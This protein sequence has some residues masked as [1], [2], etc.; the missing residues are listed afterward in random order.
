MR[1]L[2]AFKV[3]RVLRVLRVL[4]VQRVLRV[5]RVLTFL[6]VLRVLRGLRVLRVIRVQRVL[7]AQNFKASLRAVWIFS[8]LVLISLYLQKSQ[9]LTFQKYLFDSD[10]V[11]LVI[12]GKVPT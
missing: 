5:F 2:R 4:K 9:V 6:R 7:R 8:N 11:T 10:W 1:A 12:T 3:L